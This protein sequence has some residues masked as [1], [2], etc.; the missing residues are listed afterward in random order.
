M[1]RS[2]KAAFGLSLMAALALSAMS[3]IGASAQNPEAGNHFTSSTTNTKYTVTEVTGTP[4][5]VH[6]LAYFDSITCHNPQYSVHH[7]NTTTFTTL[8]VTPIKSSS[9]NCTNAKSEPADIVFN[10]CHYQFTAKA[11]SASHATVH[12]FC[13]AG[14]KLEVVNGSNIMRFG[15]QTPTSKGVTYTNTNGEITANITAEAIHLE[16]HGPCQIFGTTRV[17]A[18]MTGSVTVAGFDT[19]I[20]SKSHITAT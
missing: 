5:Q 2:L 12:F 7:T 15:T 20:G 10:E 6:L 8:T 16:C 14:K 1:I 17:D 13:P 11:R 4:H 18:K 3:V 19:T 9:W